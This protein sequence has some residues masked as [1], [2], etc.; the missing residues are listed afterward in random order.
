[1]N[2]YNIGVGLKDKYAHVLLSGHRVVWADSF[3][4]PKAIDFHVDVW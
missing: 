2:A 3:V 1:M 4:L